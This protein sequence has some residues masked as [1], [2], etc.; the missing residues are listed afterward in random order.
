MA[1]DRDDMDLDDRFEAV[2][3]QHGEFKKI[4]KA[5]RLHPSQ[6]L[7]GILKLVSLYKKPE[8]FDMASGHDVVYLADANDL[9]PMSDEDI[10][11]LTRCGFHYDSEC[12]SLAMFV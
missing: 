7:C 11:Y 4:K 1:K 12:D 3:S 10:L 9:K 5:D 8:K 2:S 6:R